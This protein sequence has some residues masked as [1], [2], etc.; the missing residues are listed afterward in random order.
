M[1][2]RPSGLMVFASAALLAGLALTGCRTAPD[3]GDLNAPAELA[4]LDGPLVEVATA[5]VVLPVVTDDTEDNRWAAM[6]LAQTIEEMC[7]RR[8]EV[9]VEG[10][11]P[12]RSVTNGLFV[13]SVSANRDY[14]CPLLKKSPEAFR[15]VTEKGSVHYVGKADFAVF[16]WCERVL[17]MRCYPVC[18]KSVVRCGEIVVPPSDYSDRPV[19]AHRQLGGGSRFWTRLSRAGGSHRGRVNVHQPSG[20]VTNEALKAIHPGIFENGE[21]PMLCYGNPETLAYYKERI[22]RH[23]AGLE[24]SGGI[25]DTNRQV[26]TVCQ[27]DAPVKC[28]C[29]HCSRL[30]DPSL[31]KTGDAS[32]IVWGHFLRQL[33]NW[34]KTAHPDYE[35]SFLPYLNTCEVPKARS[36][37]QIMGLRFQGKGWRTPLGNAEAQVCTMPGVALMKNRRCKR[38]EER[39]IRDWQAAT[40]RKVLNWHYSCWPEEW[41]AAPYVFGK[42]IREHY[43]DMADA[44]CGSY[45]CGGEGDPR[46]ALSLYVW[47]R[48]LWNPDVDVDAIYDEFAFRAFGPAAGPMR[49]LIELQETCWNRQWDDDECSH[50]NIFEVSFPPADV[51]RMRD[52]VRVAHERAV[53]SGDE[54]VVAAV[55]WYASGFEEFVAEA[56]VLAARHGRPTVVPGEE[57]EMVQARSALYPSTWAKTTVTT[58]VEGE[59]LCLTV[60]CHEPAV[61]AMDFSRTVNDYVW[62]NDCVSFSLEV[63]GGVKTAT[64]DL[65]GAVSGGWHGFSAWTSVDDSGWTVNARVRLDAAARAAG[66]LLGNVTRWRVGD[67]R[68]PAEKRVPGS[69]YE[70]SR[71]N[72]A[73]TNINADPAAFVE[74][75]LTD[76]R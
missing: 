34:L 62:G 56:D 50:H 25:V 17:G 22:D 59:E 33:S 72:T 2:R 8:P 63:D 58:A 61:A 9:F 44:M 46:M 76:G 10:V 67:R 4:F 16:D 14:A 18:G 31:G 6:V 11:R 20:W 54:S 52:L 19:F 27:W 15:V 26:V 45:V 51:A 47:L 55:E 3:W 37:F 74:F 48:C 69:R 30:V 38:N 66:R 42:T 41:T 13:G 5:Q 35:I 60:R 32:A 70:Q 57:R 28:A 24:D 21:T 65:T 12:M 40:G 43:A 1:R 53:A 7:G 36:W 49:R 73:F 68:L 64:V 39:I 71:L 23:I 29:A 75:R